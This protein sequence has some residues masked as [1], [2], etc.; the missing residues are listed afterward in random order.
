MIC[1]LTIYDQLEGADKAGYSA[2]SFFKLQL[3]EQ[4]WHIITKGQEMPRDKST[5]NEHQSCK[6]SSRASLPA[7]S[8]K[9]DSNNPNVY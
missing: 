6:I 1:V 9:E 8:L 4:T 5:L 3:R 7:P 2:E